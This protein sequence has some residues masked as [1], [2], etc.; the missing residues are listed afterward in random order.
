MTNNTNNKFRFVYRMD[1][2]LA[3][4]QKG[5]KPI[6]TLP[7]P[8]KPQFT[9]WIFETSEEFERELRALKGGRRNG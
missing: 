2:A 1:F 5:F 3:L 7:N 4:I 6:S 9:M 8:Q